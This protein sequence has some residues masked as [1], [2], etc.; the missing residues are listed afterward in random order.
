VKNINL[1]S[2][3]IVLTLLALPLMGAA[4]EKLKIYTVNYPLYYF[5][6]R[7]GGDSVDVHFPVPA[8]RDPAFWMP[9]IMLLSEYQQADL[10]L[11]NG[12]GF[13]KWLDKVSMPRS[14]VV[15]TSRS[16]KADF[17]P[18]EN[19]VTHSHGSE[20]EHS[21]I[22][23]A[24]TTW[25]DMQQAIKQAEAVAKALIRRL[26]ENKGTIEHNLHA[27]KKELSD[28]DTALAQFAKEGKVSGLLASHPRYEYLARRYHMEIRSQQ[29]EAGEIPSDEQMVE[30]NAL[31]NDSP[32][33]W[34]I[35]E[36]KPD[37]KAISLLEELNIKSIVF[38]P[39]INK[40]LEGDFMS[41][42]QDNIER[43]RLVLPKD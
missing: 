3:L 32:A 22:G 35:W 25:L 37:P 31:L 7:L 13:A 14:R 40:P 33:S 21:H 34:M 15:D 5:A 42:M 30:V 41:V 27:L 38:D 6:E 4:K 1:K 18:V 23:T 43:L 29:W 11:L 2:L 8:D 36:K 12:A 24:S 26:P 20:G 9:P 10:I 19:A 17:I 39:L 28:M 16:F